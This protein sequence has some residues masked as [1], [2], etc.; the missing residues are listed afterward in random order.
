MNFAIFDTNILIDHLKGR[1]EASSILLSCIKSDVVPACSAITVIELLCGMRPHE[2]EQLDYFLSG[3]EKVTVDNTL[4]EL[5]GLYFNR[6]RKSYGINI[7]DAI[8]AASAKILNA[9]LYTLNM[10]HFPMDDIEIVRP[11]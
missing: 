6:Y 1:Q 3:F 11:Y 7:A 4:A 10:K 2:K 8:V 9:K 5:A